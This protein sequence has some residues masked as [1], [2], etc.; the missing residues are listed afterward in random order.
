MFFVLSITVLFVIISAYFFL[1]AEK[2]QRIIIGQKRETS[3]TLKENKGLVDSMAL[4]ATKNEE[5]AKNRLI[6]LKERA[7]EQ[8]NDALIHYYELISPMVNNY[9]AI[10]R[11]CLKGKGRLQSISK[12]CFDNCDEK[13]FKEFIKLLKNEKQTKRFWSA[14]NLNGFIS[15]VEALLI[16]HEE[17]SKVIISANDVASKQLL[18]KKAAN[19]K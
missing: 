17:Q 12:K 7:Q 8:Q 5:F 14:N 3:S 16:L 9:A 18:I 6:R 15:L 19:S 1:R 2:F 4:L 11:D 10:F 13:T